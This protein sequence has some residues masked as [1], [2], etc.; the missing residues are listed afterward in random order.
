MYFNSR[1]NR[2]IKAFDEDR[3]DLAGAYSRNAVFSYRV[4][5]LAPVTSPAPSKADTFASKIGSR[6]T[7]GGLLCHFTAYV[8]IRTTLQ[9][10]IKAAALSKVV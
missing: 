8:Q 9:V 6:D 1:M 2:Y 7:S 3:S 5:E 4:H 10:L